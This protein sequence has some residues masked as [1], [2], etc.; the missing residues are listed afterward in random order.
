MRFYEGM[1]VRGSRDNLMGNHFD[2][3]G[4]HFCGWPSQLLTRSL[5]SSLMTAEWPRLRLF[6]LERPLPRPPI[7]H[8][9]LD[10]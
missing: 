4:G 1:R 3:E 5:M 7:L 8:I 10:G 2:F 6:Q 9:G